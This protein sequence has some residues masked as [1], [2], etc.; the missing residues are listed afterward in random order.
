MSL[1]I[2]PLFVTS[3]S[4]MSTWIGIVWCCV[5]LMSCKKQCHVSNN[6]NACFSGQKGKNVTSYLLFVFVVEVHFEV[7]D[8]KLNQ[9]IQTARYTTASIPL[10]LQ[11]MDDVSFAVC[12][13]Q[14]NPASASEGFLVY[15]LEV[16][17]EELLQPEPYSFKRGTK[18]R[19]YRG[20]KNVI[21]PG[22]QLAVMT[23][24][25]GDLQMWDVTSREYEGNMF[26]DP[27]V[28]DTR[29]PSLHNHGGKRI[30][31][32]VVSEDAAYLVCAGADGQTSVWDLENDINL[33][34]YYG[35]IGEV[36]A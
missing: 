30:V 3:V 28:K 8:I 35:H 16:A 21:L 1:F 24:L 19:H 17:S 2:G 11:L 18:H 22:G 34:S 31:D 36:Y 26:H 9:V 15:H 14:P 32:M 29:N 23:G 20:T 4:L 12:E 7:I 13:N 27:T 5:G 10:T 33:F 6:R 25:H